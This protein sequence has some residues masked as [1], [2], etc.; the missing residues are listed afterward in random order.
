MFYLRRKSDGQ[1]FYY[2]NG[3][4]SSTSPKLKDA[5]P[6]YELETAQ[7]M[8]RQIEQMRNE[9]YEIVE[10]KTIVTICEEDNQEI[11]EDEQ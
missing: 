4:S 3:D 5:I 9:K 2:L 10:V 7:C 6:F 11:T 1:Y 8:K